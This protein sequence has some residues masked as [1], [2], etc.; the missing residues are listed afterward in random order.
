MLPNI[1]S[2]LS[3]S[4]LAKLSTGSKINVYADMPVCI[5]IFTYFKALTDRYKAQVEG[6]Q[7]RCFWRL[8]IGITAEVG[9]ISWMVS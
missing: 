9:V 6:R 3:Y 4:I 1:S 7:L 2:T 8:E 5:S